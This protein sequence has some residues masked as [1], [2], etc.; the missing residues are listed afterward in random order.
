MS[1]SQTLIKTF[2]NPLCFGY[3]NTLIFLTVQAQEV[4]WKHCIHFNGIIQEFK[5]PLFILRKG[6]LN[7]RQNENSENQIVNF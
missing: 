2:W 5:Q 6:F 7:N 4:P 1:N 3:L